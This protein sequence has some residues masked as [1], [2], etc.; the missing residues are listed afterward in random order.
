MRD[1]KKLVL[2]IPC[3]NEEE[4]LIYSAEKLTEKIQKLINAGSISDDSGICF[5]N[6]GSFDHTADILSKLAEADKR[7]AVI[8]LSRN[9]GQQNAILAGIKTVDADMV[10]TLD[11]DL[12]DS[13]E[14]IDEMVTK[15]HEGYEIVLGCREKRF[16]DTFFK[17]YTAEIFYIIMKF[18]CPRMCQNHSEY[19]LLSRKAMNLLNEL[20]EKEIF[21]RGMISDIGLKTTKVMYNRTARIKGKTKYNYFKLFGLAWRGITNYSIFPLRFITIIGTIFIATAFFALLVMLVYFIKTGRI[22]ELLILLSSMGLFSGFIMFSVGLLGE[23]IAKILYEVK[24][25]PLYQIESTKNL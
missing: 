3:Y 5:I 6:D 19:R 25:R 2:I 16:G 4:S 23:Y 7:I 12:Q 21:L 17:K 8:N 22:N 14:S 20:P 15:Y 11:A 10:V 9:Y 1:E 24:G 18:L 13:L